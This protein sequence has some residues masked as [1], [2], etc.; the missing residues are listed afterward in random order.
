MSS[1]S[2]SPP[3]SSLVPITVSVE[4]CSVLRRVH[5]TMPEQQRKLPV[6]VCMSSVLFLF[7][8]IP[9]VTEL[10]LKRLDT[11]ALWRSAAR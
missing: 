9:G 3:S 7:L 2:L 4:T 1:L 6:M 8:G 11:Y 5:N 10:M